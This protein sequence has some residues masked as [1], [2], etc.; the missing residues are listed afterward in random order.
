M[1]EHG[2]KEQP[3]LRRAEPRRCAGSEDDGADHQ[4]FLTV[5]FSITTGCAGGPSPVPSASIALTVSIPSRDR[6][7]DG[8]VGREAGVG[9]GDDEELA[10]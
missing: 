2:G 6:A 3:L 7:D 5:T 9:C 10:P 4:L 1:L 8:V